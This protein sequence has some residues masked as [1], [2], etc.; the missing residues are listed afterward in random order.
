MRA[1]TLFTALMLA[2]NSHADCFPAPSGLVGWWPGDGNAN[3]VLGTNHGTLQGGAN[4]NT[5]G[6]V[7]N[8]F[9]FDGTNGYVSIPDSPVLRPPNFTIEA[10]VKLDAMDSPG[11]ANPGVQFF[12]FKQNTLANYFEGF[13]LGKSRAIGTDHFIFAVSSATGVFVPARSATIQTGVWYHLAAVRGSNY[14]QLYTN[15]QFAAQA[16]VNFPQDYGNHPLYLGTSGQPSYDAKLKGNLDE[17]TLYNRALSSNE[18]AAVFATG[19][20]GKCKAPIITLQPQGQAVSVGDPVNFSVAA[21]GFAPLSYQWRFNDNPIP[22]ATN[23]SLTVSNVQPA[24]QGNYSVLVSNAIGSALSSNAWLEVSAPVLGVP[25]IVTIN[26]AV[27]RPGQNVSISGF[28]FSLAAASNIVRFGAVR[29]DVVTASTTNLIVTVPIGATYAPVSVT[30]TGLTAFA[31]SSFLPTFTGDGQPI[32]G[33]TFAARQDLTAGYGNFQT[34]IAD[35][36]AD[37]KPDLAIGN[38][39][40]HTIWLF[41]NIGSVGSLSAGSFAAPVVFIAGGSFEGPGGLASADLD[42]DGKLELFYKDYNRVVIMRNLSEPGILSSN[43]FAAPVYVN[44]LDGGK[45][46]RTRDL[47][48]DG[49]P[50]LVS[51]DYGNGFISVARNQSTPGVLN[52]GSFAPTFH[53]PVNFGPHD[54]VVQDFDGDGKPDIVA[55]HA[56]ASTI[57]L[58]RNISTSGELTAASFAP[59]VDMPA[60]LDQLSITAGDVDGDGKPDLVVGGKPNTIYVYRNQSSPGSLTNG[61]FAAPV[62][63]GNPGWVHNV[64][65]GD[66]NGDGKPDLIAV[67]ELGSF[68]CAYQNQSAPGSF[69][70][71]SLAPRVDF[72]TGWNAW[73]VSV[74]DLDGDMRPDAVLCNNYETFGSLYRNVMPFGGSPVIAAQPSSLFSIVGSPAQ[75]TANV[76]GQLPLAYQWFFNGTPLADSASVSGALSNV[77]TLT[78]TQTNDIGSYWLVATNTLGSVTSAV[79]TLDVGFAP[80]ITTQPV[81]L[82]NLAGTS[83]EFFVAATGSP[84]LQYQWRLNCTNISSATASNLVIAAAQFVDQG[85]YS[86]IVANNFGSVTSA[87]AYLTVNVPAGI[88]SSPQSLAVSLGNDAVFSASAAGN[89]S[90]SVQWLFNGLPLAEGGRFL[91]TTQT[92]LTILNAQTDDAGNYQIVATNQF[93]SATSAVAAL[94]VNLPACAPVGS[95]ALA[96]WAADSSAYDQKGGNLIQMLNGTTFISGKVVDA[97]RFDGV[98]DYIQVTTSTN[99][100][101]TL[102]AGLTLE[103]WLNPS[104][105][106]A[107]SVAEWSSGPQLRLSEDQA[108]TGDGVGNIYANLVDANGV[109]H[110]IVSPAGLMRSNSFQHVVLTYDKA[111]GQAVL[112]RNGIA[113]QSANLG[114]FTVNT[115]AALTFGVRTTGPFSGTYFKGVLDEILVYNRALTATEIKDSYDASSAGHCPLPPVVNLQPQSQSVSAGTNVILSAN[116]LGSFE[117]SYQWLFNGNPLTNGNGY[118]WVNSTTLHITNAQAVHAGDYRLAFSNAAGVAQSDIATLTV[119]P[120]PATILQQP[121]SVTATKGAQVSLAAV[122]TGT[123]PLAYQWLFNGNALA[124]ATSSSILF[125]NVQF[126]DAGVYAL[127]VTN[128]LASVTSSTATL[129]VTPPPGFLWTRKAGGANADEG[130]SM[131]RDSQGNIFVA[132]Q[133]LGSAAFG[134]IALVNSNNSLDVFLAKYDSAGQLLWVRSAG[135]VGADTLNGIAVDA[136]NNVCISGSVGPSPNFSG[137][138]LT[139]FGGNDAFIAK[140]S[141]AG[142]LLWA[143]NF[144]GTATDSAGAIATD[145]A[146]RIFVT[147]NFSGTGFFGGTIISNTLSRAAFIARFSADG[148]AEWVRVSSGNATAF[149]VGIALDSQTNVL[150]TGSFSPTFITF[151][152]L[153]ITNNFTSP[154]AGF[155]DV[156]VVKYDA[157][158]NVLWAQKAGGSSSENVRGIAVDGG[159]N[160]YIVGEF[161]GTAAFGG[162]TLTA[163][164]QTPDVYVMKCDPFGT[165][166]WAKRAGGTSTDIGSGVAVDGGGNVF[167]TGSYTG[168]G[169]FGGVY[170]PPG[171][172]LPNGGFVGGTNLS[173][174]GGTDAFVAMYSTVGELRWALRAGGNSA[175]AG[176]SILT[177]DRGGLFLTGIFSTTAAFGHVTNTVVGNYD[178]FLSKLVAF[179]TDAP[180]ALIAQ[181]TNQ[182]NAAGSTINLTAGVLAPGPIGYQW[183]FNGTDIPGATNLSLTLVNVI[184]TN[185]GSYS[186][187]ITTPNGNLSS[188][189]AVL[190]VVTEPDFVWSKHLGG[191]NNDECLAVAADANGNTYAAGYFSGTTDFGVTNLTSLGGEDGFVAKFDAAQNLV[192]LVQLGGTN[193]DRANALALDS[194]GNVIVAG[195]FSATVDCGGTNLTSFGSNDVFLARFDS[196]GGLLWARQAGNTNSDFA[197]SVAVHPNGDIAVAGMFQLNAVFD[198]VTVTNRN[199]SGWDIFVA[200]YDSTGQLLWVNGAGGNTSPH[201]DRVRGVAFDPSGNVMMCGSFLYGITFGTVALNNIR[202]GQEIFVAKYGPTGNVAW[203]RAITGIIATLDDEATA[204]AVNRDGSVFLAGYFQNQITFASNTV[205]AASTNMPDLF[206]AKYDAEGNALWL[207]AGGGGVM[208]AA[209]ALATDNSGNALLAGSFTG[210]AQFGA[211]SV[212]GIGGADAFAAVYDAT[213]NLLKLRK[214]GGMGDDA[215]QAAAYD[216]RGNLVLGGFHTGPAVVGTTPLSGDGGRDAFV[217]KLSLYD[218]DLAPF[219]TTQPMEQTVGY[220]KILDLGVGVASGPSPAYQWL[221]NNAPLSGATNGTL[222]LTNFQYAAVGDYAVIITNVFGAVTSSVA[223]VT[224]EIFPEFPWLQRAGSTG[225]D[226]ALAL[227]MDA[228]TNLY[229]AGHFSGTALFT[230]GIYGTN[231][232]LVSTGATDI[233]LTKHNAAG[234][235]LW[236]RRAGGTHEDSAQ[237]LAIDP[238]GN[239]LL[240]G[241]FRSTQARFGSLVVTN[242]SSDFLGDIFAAKYDTDGNPLWAKRAGGLG[243]DI[244]RSIATDAEGNAYI[245]GY[246]YWLATFDSLSITNGNSNFVTNHFV[247]K[248]DS[249][250][251]AVWARNAITATTAAV[252]GFGITVDAS[253]NII[254]T[255]H[256]AGTANF[257]SGFL[258]NTAGGGANATS[259]NVFLTK[260]D[261]NGNL[262]WAKKGIGGAPGIGLAVRADSEGNILATSC[263][264]AFGG[265]AYVLAKYDSNG[266]HSWMRGVLQGNGQLQASSLA[267]AAD[268]NIF[269]VG[270]VPAGVLTYEGTQFSA[271]SGFVS[272]YRPDGVPLWVTFAGAWCHG[273][274]PDSAGGAYLAGRYS[275]QGTFGSSKTNFLTGIGGN[276]IFFVKLGVK[277]PTAT[278]QAFVK[279][280]ATDAGTTLQ[281]TTTGTGPFAYQ[282]RFN[283]TNISGATGSSYVLSGAKWTNA[284]LYSVVI[285][286]TAGRFESAAAAVNVMPELYSEPSGADVKLTWDGLFTLQSST[287]PVGPFADLPGAIS[288]HFYSTSNDPLQFFRLKSEPFALTISNQPGTGITLS[289]AGISGYNFIVLGSTNLSTWTPLATNISPFSI[290]ETN[291]LPVQFYRAIMAQ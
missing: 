143:T 210:P 212:T 122:A 75:F 258:T 55:A 105:L 110:V 104:V 70:A 217:T 142:D 271:G 265:T 11:T 272:K 153:A 206:L 50:D 134:T 253:T 117:M 259:G 88:L 280:L 248:Y 8:A 150:V 58:F 275:Q 189:S 48:G 262:L 247:A 69:T 209:L 42:G 269:V 221:F 91:G 278:P 250:G 270:G 261:R 16:T 225:D 138:I 184:A 126:A 263:W 174:S 151:N 67:G 187:N 20:A 288:P 173:N 287:N 28:N 41:R 176:N 139:N 107:R 282:W 242:P 25:Y 9:N 194:G 31:R 65:L 178:I 203:A 276:D 131:A 162:T 215:A 290:T 6:L 192:W 223:T 54:V 183:Q 193:N 197:R 208:D 195:Q 244:A 71:A 95:G 21:T 200:R 111:S 168:T 76:F 63:F 14:I 53:L 129:T 291:P 125:T 236:A 154:T 124:G 158:G 146:G 196:A 233:F 81:S 59:R 251:A 167:V 141:G 149:G 97:F 94:T 140:Y 205:F 165:I 157:N 164:G 102:A 181:P 188:T 232:S 273:V 113:V 119:T 227:A 204:L 7:A 207:R 198:G 23:S 180:A 177:D 52:S 118:Y 284:G 156:F 61:S 89:P 84:V 57:T 172:N 56:T 159:G 38:G 36:D 45:Y 220:G 148:N 120:V 256:F 283:G 2:V 68:L 182:T 255:G 80:V 160:S 66:I 130:R 26:P 136:A 33:S 211:Q 213:G 199:S 18:I 240:T 85:S 44:T 64:V 135:G 79:V 112:Y 260:Y 17:V 98:D 101:L 214:L 82:T 279:T 218:P 60:F 235:L 281:V 254:V 62:S 268:G 78:G 34:H 4:A 175:D 163:P 137:T 96:W 83:A 92:V 115:A 37:G 87:V 15:G 147:G 277:S 3:N 51:C 241:Y 243:W 74:G 93:G 234:K 286:N 245:T 190:T 116:A 216:G 5:P 133:I 19:A 229:L 155:S 49:R 40:A 114:S 35:F 145:G 10:W 1:L 191:T 47:D 29:A 90:P 237:S 127:V 22:G 285:S 289:G 228:Q 249:N 46:V 186:V 24:S 219:I 100:S 161:D 179:D 109:S 169:N 246:C 103:A 123:E 121:V 239:V 252:Q 201:D 226:Q 39:S 12:V 32:S 77:L 202:A 13:W 224:V 108:V 106:N 144:G 274:V 73:G 132:G 264:P 86:V 30:V 128:D 266:F 152:N 72:G 231:V 185:G 222:R 267:L 99:L 238:A 257:G 170:S 171:F 27:A 43:S 230:N 166:L